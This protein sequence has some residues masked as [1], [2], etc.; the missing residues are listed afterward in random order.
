MTYTLTNG[1]SVIRDADAA[2]IPNEP[3]NADWQTYQTWLAAGNTPSPAAPVV[4][5]PVVV[6]GVVFLGRFT[7]AEYM[8]IKQAGQSS[9][10]V[11][12]WIDT[13]LM[14][15]AVT[16]SS[17]LTQAA[18]AGLVAA[19]LLTPARADAIFR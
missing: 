18:K 9:A 1:S 3:L 11:S 16:V 13:G 10:Q 6:D 14:L 8:A 4:P 7:D 12:R 2:W 15:G 19:G 5:P 17:P